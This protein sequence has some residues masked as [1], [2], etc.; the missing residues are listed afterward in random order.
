MFLV[1]LVLFRTPCAW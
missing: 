1:F